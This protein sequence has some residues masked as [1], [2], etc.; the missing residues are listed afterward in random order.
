[1]ASNQEG[2]SCS[3]FHSQTAA[4]VSYTAGVVLLVPDACTPHMFQTQR[5]ASHSPKVTQQTSAPLCLKMS[6]CLLKV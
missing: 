5:G 1:M 4:L 2:S 6:T 3:T